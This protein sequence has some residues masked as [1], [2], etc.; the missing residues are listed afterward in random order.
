ME[1]NRGGGKGKPLQ[2]DEER[3]VEE[4]KSRIREKIKRRAQK[5]EKEQMEDG[6]RMLAVEPKD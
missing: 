6:A 3:A 2:N 5:T 1:E 4:S